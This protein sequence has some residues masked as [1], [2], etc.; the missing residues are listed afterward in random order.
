MAFLAA[1]TTMLTFAQDNEANEV[2]G[3]ALQY[4]EG[5]PAEP[6]SGTDVQTIL[7]GILFIL[8]F[9][10][11]IGHMVYEL[12]I[13]QNPFKHIS[14]EE[15][16]VIRASEG[17]PEHMTDA[18]FD[19]CRE[20]LMHITDDWTPIPNTDDEV[21]ITTRA[22]MK[23]AEEMIAQ[24]KG[25]RPTDANLVDA[26]NEMCDA[27][28][29]FRK[30]EFTGSKTLMVI[31][32]LVGAFAIWQAGWGMLPFF[33]FNA[34]T[35]VLASMT[36]TFMVLRRELK[37]KNSAGCLSAILGGAASMIAGAQTVRTVT[38]WSDG[39]TTTD[40]D[41]SE[42][43]IAWILAIV[44]AVTLALLMFIWAVVNYLRNY[45]IFR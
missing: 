29:Q 3:D 11:M 1:L 31:L 16:K 27:I 34:V 39:T 20:V 15:M 2:I 9:A 36:P 26:T 35:Y 43:Y 42:H 12:W 41:H 5:Y 32:V 18:E 4:T 25:Y 19:A 37:G 40:D 24:V 6:T 13:R 8:A 17:A 38:K 14:V 30:R 10:W 28:D 21:I 33:I 22:Q 23:K 45:V 7:I 44:V